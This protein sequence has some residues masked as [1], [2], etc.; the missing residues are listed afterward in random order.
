MKMKF[1]CSVQKIMWLFNFFGSKK[2]WKNGNIL[3]KL[4]CKMYLVSV[5]GKCYWKH[6]EQIKRSCSVAKYFRDSALW[7]AVKTSMD[8]RYIKP[9]ENE[10]TMINRYPQ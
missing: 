7:D 9:D 6:I 5:D 1:V 3:K 4:S 10:I 2:H 8:E